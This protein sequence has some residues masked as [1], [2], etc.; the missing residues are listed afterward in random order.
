MFV[1]VTSSLATSYTVEISRSCLLPFMGSSFFLFFLQA[2]G[3]AGCQA[4]VE[5]LVTG[6]D[7][8]EMRTAMEAL[9]I[10]VGKI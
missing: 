7:M 8:D 2:E 3:V 4:G 6:D 10:L 1:N 5:T 9:N